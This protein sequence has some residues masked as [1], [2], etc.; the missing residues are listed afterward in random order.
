[1]KIFNTEQSDIIIVSRHAGFVAL[2]AEKGIKGRVIAHATADDVRGNVVIGALPLHLAC[3]ARMVGTLEMNVPAHMRGLDLSLEECRVLV[4]NK[5][6]E[7]FVVRTRDGQ[8]KLLNDSC[9]SGH[10][11][12]SGIFASTLPEEVR[13][14]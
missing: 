5:N 13:G 9:A 8:Q 12:G 4:G 14:W 1:M 10:Q 3:L 6:I 11:G 2:L 7:W